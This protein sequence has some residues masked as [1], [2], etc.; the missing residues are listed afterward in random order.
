MKFRGGTQI[1]FTD[2]TALIV[3]DEVNAVVSAIQDA[4]S[5]QP[6]GEW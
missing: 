1:V 2:G 3:K 6:L 4:T 5:N